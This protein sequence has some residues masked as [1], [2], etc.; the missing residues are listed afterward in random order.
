MKATGFA[1]GVL[2]A[3]W[4]A[5]LS[6]ADQAAWDA[7][8]QAAEAG[9]D[10]AIRA[11]TAEVEF[12]QQF[13]RLAREAR[14]GSAGQAKDDLQ[15]AVERLN[16]LRDGS[17]MPEV[18]LT[19]DCRPGALGV[20]GGDRSG[21]GEVVSPTSIVLIRGVPR[22][23]VEVSPTGKS[24]IVFSGTWDMFLIDGVTTAGVSRD[25]VI[26][27]GGH[28]SLV[29][30]LALFECVEVR[31]HEFSDGRTESLPV[32]RQVPDEEWAEQLSAHT[33]GR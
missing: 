23:T 15:K 20:I 14:D 26:R 5:M 17:L 19:G 32:L 31:E 9:R 27:R 1:A 11:A 2:M 16:G 6:A 33:V 13:L 24:V 18:L 8:F 28:T 7:Y 29:D 4:A 10:E 3:S 22:R 12:R 30:P 21:V 25:A